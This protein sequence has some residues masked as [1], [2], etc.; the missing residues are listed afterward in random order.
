MATSDCRRQIRNATPLLL[1][2]R[3]ET[4]VNY[5]NED[6]NGT[7]NGLANALQKMTQN[8]QRSERR[9]K[10]VSRQTAIGQDIKSSRELKGSLAELFI[11]QVTDTHSSHTNGQSKD[12][13]MTHPPQTLLPER[14]KSADCEAKA[15]CSDS[16]SRGAPFA[17]ATEASRPKH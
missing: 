5:R 14:C 13:G 9:K 12:H 7:N 17:R 11:G 3:A 10:D 1:A 15:L 16:A 8:T 2:K 4:T 6:P